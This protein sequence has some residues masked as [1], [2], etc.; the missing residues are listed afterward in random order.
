MKRLL[1]LAS[2]VS[3]SLLGGWLAYRTTLQPVQPFLPDLGVLDT[4]HAQVI[5]ALV[6]NRER[7]PGATP[8]EP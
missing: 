4:W 1:V 6:V 5:G 8:G 7:D 2:L 3:A